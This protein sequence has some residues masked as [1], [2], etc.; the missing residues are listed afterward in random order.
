MTAADDHRRRPRRRGPALEA[1]IFD[2]V[3]AELTAGGYAALSMD[4][5]A[6]R[7]RVSKAS[8]YR[9]WP[10]RAELV[11]DAVHTLL[12]DPT[13]L[14][15]TGTLRGDLLVAFGDLADRLSGPAGAA[16]RGVLAD[17]LRDDAASQVLRARR[18][19]RGVQL[20]LELVRR[21]HGRGEV[22]ADAVTPRQLEVGHA[23]VRHE[24]LVHGAV[25][26]AFVAELVDEVVLPLLTAAPA[27]RA[28]G[29]APDR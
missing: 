6:E 22:D 21:A 17:A 9:R 26:P 25:P 16:L 23:M 1:A 20:V 28:G 5:V 15:D 27:A 19:G 14:P 2:A 18:Q 13:T 11:V 12:P 8:L 7:A 29:G 4:A 24:F 3:L 10:G